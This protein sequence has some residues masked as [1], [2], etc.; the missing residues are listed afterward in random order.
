MPL[1]LE[2]RLT[3]LLRALSIR[4]RL[5][6]S[7]VLL[8]LLP[9]LVSGYISYAESSREIERRTRLFATEVVKQV[10]KN[11]QLQMLE[12]ETA[13]EA[14]VLS[15]GVQAALARY[16]V[17]DAAEKGRARA[18]LTKILLDSYGSFEDVSQ[19]YFL[20]KDNRILDP[21]V[22]GQLGGALE[23]FAAAAPPRRGRPHWGALDLWGGQKSIVMLRQV[24][25]KSNNRLAGSLFLGVRP[26]HF[27]GIFDN[28]QLGEGSDIFI[29]DG[30]D[31]S[32]VVQARE[33]PNGAPPAAGLLAELGASLRHGQPG[34]FAAYEDV[35]ADGRGRASYRAAYAQIPRTSWYVVSTL[36]NDSLLAQAQS[37]RDKILLIG[38]LCFVGALALA[39]LIARSISAPLE[40]LAAL[41]RATEGGNYGLRMDYTGRD[42]LAQLA[43]KFN[44]MAGN[45]GQ[46]HEQ[47]ESRVAAR[48]S[49]LELANEKLATLSM[50]DALTGIANRRR[51][52]AV[53][54][55]ELH[56]AGRCGQP[57]A[58]LMIDV[59]HFKSYNDFYGHQDGDACLLRVARLLHGHA[60]RAGDLAARYGGEEFVMLAA[61]TDLETAAALAEGIRLALEQAGLPHA[62]SPIG[63][64]SVSIGVAVLLP[65]ERQSGEMFIRMADKA[66]YRAKQQ[67]RNQV[68]LAGG[69][70]I[71]AA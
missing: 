40:R 53:L 51:F 25:F 38:L 13:S 24:Y 68:Q 34:G 8:S 11:V 7:F 18:E 58:L 55:A 50:T 61:D 27:A 37:V 1:S 31:G 22:L 14:L 48:T 63:C 15:D 33:R 66:M 70:R 52:D 45:I 26:L 57:L 4:H 3:A 2:H 16:A 60:R 46:A 67:G 21:Q 56:R 6:A 19:K 44:E 12:V 42:E 47:L 39:Y 43:R 29:L 9:L 23:Q 64:V 17:D 65:D 20:D 71:A 36:P 49:E 41:M 10:A 69:R 5:I 54:E 28:V 30:R 32:A 59:D 62:E 35:A